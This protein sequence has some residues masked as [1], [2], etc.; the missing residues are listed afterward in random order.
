MCSHA[1]TVTTDYSVICTCCGLERPLLI[2]VMD[3]PTSQSSAPLTRLYNRG[4]RWTSIVKKIV[5][6]HSGPSNSDPVWKYLEKHKDSFHGPQDIIKCLRKSNLKN[7][8]YPCIH[9]FTK[10]FY[11]HYTAPPEPP[12]MVVKMLDSYFNHILQL[13]S[14]CK[15]GEDQFF[16]YNWL[17]EQG[18]HLYN[19]HGYFPYVKFLK[20]PHRRQRYVTLLLRL[21]GTRVERRNHVQLESRSQCEKSLP[22]IPRNRSPKPQRPPKQNA[23]TR[24]RPYFQ[25]SQL[26]QLYRYAISR[27]SPGTS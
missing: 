15:L 1:T 3:Y 22:S 5:G 27:G 24:L 19:L 23:G 7:K 11:K 10:T 12:K 9:L 8:H 16:S 21:Y 17:I 25:D 26:D 18:L 2:N 14:T 6:I 13:W 4:D 20:C